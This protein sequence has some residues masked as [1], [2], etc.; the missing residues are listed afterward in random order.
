M[1]NRFRTVIFAVLLIALVIGCATVPPPSS[2]TKV[3]LKDLCDNFHVE[4]HRD[5]VTQVI[6]LR[7]DALK[8]Q[9]LVG[10]SSVIL[11]TE[12]ILLSGSLVRER[13]NVVVPYDFK[14]KVIDRLIQLRPSVLKGLRRIVIDPG[15]GGKDPGALGRRGTKEKF[16]VQ[17]IAR[18][19]KKSLEKKGIDIVMTRDSDKFVTLEKRT[20]IATQEKADLFVS[21]H[22]NSSPVRRVSGVEVWS[23]RKLSD[24]EKQ[25]KPRQNNHHLFFD[26]L[27]MKKNVPDVKNIVSDM[28]YGYKQEES[29]KLSSFVSKRLASKLQA[30]NRGAKQSGFFVLRN[31]LVPAILVEVGFLSNSREEKLLKT[32]SYRQKIADHLGESL[33]D[34]INNNHL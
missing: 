11:G 26:K 3:Y 27:A 2:L 20:E 22:A 1:K 28:L 4:C 33:I 30:R 19:L 5:R 9:A 15:H 7:K 31:T 10:S 8:A 32:G 13:N 12:T 14:K 29:R 21:V 17:D 16:V 24:V 6:T 18:R 23:G 25:E 34:Y